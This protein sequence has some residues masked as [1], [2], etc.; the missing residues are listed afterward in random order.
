MA[1]TKVRVGVIED[2]P[3]GIHSGGTL[4]HSASTDLNF[5]GT[6]HTFT[7]NGGT[8]NISLAGG[9]GGGA[10][11]VHNDT[12]FAYQNVVD[13]DATISAPY[14]TGTIY[15]SEDVTVDIEEGVTLTVDDNCVLNI[16]VI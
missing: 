16:I 12:I 4:I 14:S 2:A 5:V 15:A 7:V 3:V 13:A 8:T 6:G 11:K 9:G 10:S 1:L